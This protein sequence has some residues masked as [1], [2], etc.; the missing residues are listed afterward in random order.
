MLEDFRFALRQLRRTPVF[1]CVTILT[2]ALGIG[3]NTAVFSVM[4]AVVV[5]WLPVA[6]PEQLVFLH[7]TG[8]P[9]NSSQT[10]HD[11][12]SLTLP[13]YEQLRTESRIFSDLIAFVPLDTN[14]TAIR[15]GSEPETAWADM[16]SGNFFSGL[17]VR[18]AR[19]RALT[20]DDERR[21]TQDAGLSYGFWTRRFG[22]NPSIVG[23][24]LFVKACPSRSSALQARSSPASS[25]TTQPTCGFPFRIVPS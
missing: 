25:T 24:T 16:G 4:N 13:I 17:G 20:M 23:D 11:D 15:H 1:A 7:T 5:Q 6:H 21:H 14:R 18:M 19:G 9:S 2:L 22:R 8:Q 3:A 10:G 12:T